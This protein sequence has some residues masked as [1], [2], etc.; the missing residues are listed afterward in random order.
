MNTW[1]LHPALVHFP[2]ALLLSGVVLDLYAAW[3][4]R[5]S[6]DK[7]IQGLLLFG[8]ITGVLAALSGLLAYY[9]VPAHTSAAH[10]QMTWH[11]WIQISAILL[12]TLATFFRWNV[13]TGS[14]RTIGRWVGLVAALLL[15]VGSFLGGSLVFHG[16][17]GVDPAILAPEIREGHH[18]GDHGHG[19]SHGDEHDDHAH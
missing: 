19:S 4:H 10:E 5:K 17:A 3:W 16:G 15:V 7:P 11:L 13:V 6:L 18:H 1:E 2:I 12:F 14:R 8:S 9:T